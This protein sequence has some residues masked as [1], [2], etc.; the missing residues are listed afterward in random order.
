VPDSTIDPSRSAGADDRYA[1]LRLRDVRLYLISRFIATLGQNMLGMAVGWELYERTHSALALGLVGLAQLSP[2]LILTLPAGHVADQRDRRGIVL[3][4]NVLMALS[5]AGLTFVSWERL[6]VAG[7]YFFLFISG[8]ARAFLSPAS[9]A[10]LPQIVP[11][12]LFPAAITWSSG[13]Y[14]L[15]A[16]LGPVLGGLAIPLTGGA[17][18]VYAFNVV[19]LVVCGILLLFVRVPDTVVPPP[20][21]KMT[22][23]NL[24]AGLRF[25]LEHRII[26]GIISLDLFAVLLGG[27]TAL[28]PIYAK[29]ILHVG[30]GGLGWLRAALPIG[31]CSMAL[32]QAHRP[33]LARAGHAL[34]LAVGGFGLATVIFGVSR[35]FWLSLAMMAACGALDNVSVIVRHTLV[36]VLTPDAMRGRV[37]AINGL[38]IGASNEFGEF[39]SGLVASFAGPVISAVSGG[40][41]TIL[42]V[43]A[44]AWIW[45]EIRKY[46]SLAA[47]DSPE[48]AV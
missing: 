35:W 11:R 39:E 28:L 37:S 27:A 46:G 15:S 2:M 18:A 40:I 9:S 29:D 23:H 17:T 19:A 31:S 48:D 22:L 25:V 20:R 5:Y 3:W 4:M 26:L 32:F 44:T 16:A 1:V 45:P 21:E 12:S 8:V 41:G 7:T 42:V 34:L 14:Q 43:I 13:S 24:V 10:L 6:P 33:P 47:S 30:A 38:F 36:Q